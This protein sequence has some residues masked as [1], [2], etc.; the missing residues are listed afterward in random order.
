[1][2]TPNLST[3]PAGDK[4]DEFCR[5]NL[6]KYRPFVDCVENAYDN[7]TDSEEIIKKWEQFSSNLLLSGKIVPGNLRREFERVANY[8]KKRKKKKKIR[9]IMKILFY[10]RTW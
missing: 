8:N 5:L 1:M 2:F 4:Y 9:I 10:R 3:D 6:I 7:L